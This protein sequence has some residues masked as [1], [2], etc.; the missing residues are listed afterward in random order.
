[1]ATTVPVIETIGQENK[2]DTYRKAMIAG[3][4]NQQD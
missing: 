3:Y 4:L 1:M 2:N